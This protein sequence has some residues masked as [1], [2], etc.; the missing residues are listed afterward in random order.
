MRTIEVDITVAEGG[1]AAL[2]IQLPADV[3]PGKHRA[4]MVLDERPAE[5]VVPT[6]PNG[7]PPLDFPVHDFGPW[8]ENLSLR[9]ED[10]YGDEGR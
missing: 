5:S 1:K 7:R 3:P 10:L 2:E 4:V 8:P 9:R 6:P